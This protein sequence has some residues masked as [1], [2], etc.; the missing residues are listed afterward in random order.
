MAVE[1]AIAT[2]LTG[3]EIIE[4]CV[5]EYRKRLGSLSPLQIGKE[6]A[7]FEATFQSNLKLFRMGHNGGGEKETLAWGNASGGEKTGESEE[8]AIIADNFKSGTDVNQVREDHDLPLT[9]ESTDGRGGKIRKKVRV[10]DIV[11]DVKKGK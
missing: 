4:V 11:K 8:T 10:K 5:Q 2:P 6:Y 9:V 1:K 7:G 3:D